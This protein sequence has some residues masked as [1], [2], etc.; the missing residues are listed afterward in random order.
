MAKRNSKSGWLL[1]CMI[2]VP[3]FWWVKIGITHIGI[4]ALKRALSISQSFVGFAFPIMILPIPGAYHIE[5]RI[6]GILKPIS[7]K[8]YKGD[9]ASEW[10]WAF[11]A[12]FVLPIMLAIWGVYLALID[13][14]LGTSI[15]TTVSTW[16]FDVVFFL[17][18]WIFGFIKNA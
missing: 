10:F 12:I 13:R 18:E 2:G 16:F 4:G 17:G 6:H 9:G 1:Y 14:L 15:L 11:A 3:W 8:F 7:C 5:Q